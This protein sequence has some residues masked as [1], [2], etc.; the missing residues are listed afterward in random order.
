MNELVA[1]L[2]A[3]LAE[4][5]FANPTE[6]TT[7]DRFAS[8]LEHVDDITDPAHYMPGHLTASAFAVDPAEGSLLLVHHEKLDRW[9][10][11]GGHIEPTDTALEM[12]ARRELEE[13]TGL[14]DAAGLGLLDLDVHDIPA[15]SDVPAHAHFDVRFAFRATSNEIRALEGV[16]DCAWVLFD[17][18]DGYEPD[19]SVVRSAAKLRRLIG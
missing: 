19:E 2:R 6:A 10:Q 14:S 5:S 18:L 16:R 9:L 15:R 1:W 17:Q 8:L 4:Y 7:V 11:P 3:H 12:A 13:E